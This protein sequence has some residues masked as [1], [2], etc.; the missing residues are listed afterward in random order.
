MLGHRGRDTILQLCGGPLK[1]SLWLEHVSRELLTAP[2]HV[3]KC[4]VHPRERLTIG[5]PLVRD[6]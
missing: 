4:N 6:G 3:L 2:L 1:C 5:A